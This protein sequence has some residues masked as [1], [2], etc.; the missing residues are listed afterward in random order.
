MSTT[1]GQ[2]GMV[3]SQSHLTHSLS[4][5]VEFLENYLFYLLYYTYL[6]ILC[7]LGTGFIILKC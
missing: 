4:S 6:K 7:E 1:N 5:N 3:F 2:H